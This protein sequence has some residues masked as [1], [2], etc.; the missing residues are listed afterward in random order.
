MQIKKCAFFRCN[1][2]QIIQRQQQ[3]APQVDHHGFLC[4][5]ELGLQTVGGVRA[6][7][8]DIALLPLVDRLLSDP[9]ALGQDAGGFIA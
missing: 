9:E 6:V 4:W 2:Q 1:S 5:R 8:K 3:G 7:S